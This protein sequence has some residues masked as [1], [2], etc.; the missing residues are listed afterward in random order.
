M[1][2]LDQMTKINNI[3]RTLEK[4][5]QLSREEEWAGAIKLLLG[6]HSLLVIN[7]TIKSIF[8]FNW[9]N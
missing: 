7:Q 3:H 4:A 9:F 2:L 1:A 5:E 8:I 6:K